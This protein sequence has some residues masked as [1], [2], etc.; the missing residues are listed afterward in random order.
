MVIALALLSGPALGPS[1][2]AGEPNDQGVPL[3]PLLGWGVACLVV[4]WLSLLLAFDTLLTA[5]SLEASRAAARDEDFARAADEARSA[6]ALQPW[7]AEPRLQLALAYEADGD[8]TR[9]SEAAEEA[10]AR[11]RDDWLIW[12][13]RARIATRDGE[14]DLAEA[15]LRQARR[16]NPRAPLFTSLDGPLDIDGLPE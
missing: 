2:E 14:I 16:L 4:G 7:A 11:A 12:L 13:A 10:S 5:R 9:A 15:A 8:L 6:I 3:R 1:D